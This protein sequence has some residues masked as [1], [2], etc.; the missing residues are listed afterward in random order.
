[1]IWHFLSR[2][3]V[4]D[5]G[6]SKKIPFKPYHSVLKE[7]LSRFWDS[8]RD[9]LTLRDQRYLPKILR[10]LLF[11]R[12][13]TSQPWY[14]YTNVNQRVILFTINDYF[15][16][17]ITTKSCSQHLEQRNRDQGKVIYSRRYWGKERPVI[18]KISVYFIFQTIEKGFFIPLLFHFL[19]LQ[20]YECF[21]RLCLNNV[22][23]A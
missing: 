7:N 19:G 14:W 12:S 5:S 15:F 23:I 22:L 8:S 21:L 1:M 10:N 18:S 2:P 16:I 9:K 11:L 6:V 17:N 20:F 13:V 3:A 4:E